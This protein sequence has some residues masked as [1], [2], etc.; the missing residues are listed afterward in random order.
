MVLPSLASTVTIGGYTG[1]VVGLLDD[2]SIQLRTASGFVTLNPAGIAIT[3]PNT[4]EEPPEASAADVPFLAQGTN[5]GVM[6]DTTEQVFDPY[7]P[8]QLHDVGG[9]HAL[10]GPPPHPE[11]GMGAE[12]AD[13][14]DGPGGVSGAGSVAVAGGAVAQIALRLLRAAMGSVT[15]I[16]AQHWN[17]LPAWARSIL[18]GVGIGVGVDLAADIPGVPGES[19]IRRFGDDG[20]GSALAV[21]HVTPHLVDGHLG[22]HVV[23]SWVANGVTFYRLSDGKLAVQNKQ[24]RWK[25]WR[26]KKPIVIMPTGAG[27]L[28]TLLRADAVL[29]RQAKRI[30]TMLNRRAPRPKRGKAGAEKG[31]I[32]L[33]EH[34]KTA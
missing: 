13:L 6:V 1:T 31:V 12:G 28:R 30:A 19:F 29:N 21:Q 9:G 16:T 32:V 17:S 5:G 8:G 7:G 14:R 10:G 15:R 27:D 24:G 11:H 26:P 20:S 2:G 25:V 22:A 3:D 18:A 34:G 4:G 33:Q 23:G